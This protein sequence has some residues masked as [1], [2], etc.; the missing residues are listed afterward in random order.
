M[1]DKPRDIIHM[2]IVDVAEAADVSEPTVVRFCRAVGTSGFQEFK[3]LLAQEVATV[4]SFPQMP[5]SPDDTVDTITQKIFDATGETLRKVR[6]QLNPK[7]LEE[8]INALE[9]ARR[10]E[11]FGFG[12]SGSVAA[13]AQHKFFRLQI[14]AS[15]CSDHHIQRMSAMGMSTGDIVVALSQSGRT[16]ALIDSMRLARQ[17]G[18]TVI[19]IAPSNS[20]VAQEASIHID[21][22]V[23]DDLDIYTPLTARITHLLVIDIL[24]FGIAQ[25]KGEDLQEHLYKLRFGLTDLRV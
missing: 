25:R 15:A 4:P 1:L 5:V 13:D 16:I 10:V 9:H 7:R 17:Q 18:A 6:D 23:E 21:V 20:P 14:S 2:R 12:A 22:D 24:A 3:L 19:A 8:A 11:F